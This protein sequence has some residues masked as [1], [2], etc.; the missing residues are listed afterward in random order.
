MFDQIKY[1]LKQLILVIALSISIVQPSYAITAADIPPAS[2]IHHNYIIDLADILD[3]DTEA[4][5]NSAIAILQEHKNKAIYL[6]TV[7]AITEIQT[8]R[9]FKIIPATSPSRRFL[10]SILLNWNI[11]QLKQGNGI[12]FFVS[13]ADH[14]VEIRSGFNLKYILQDRHIQGVIDKIIIPKFKHSNFNKGI[15]LAIQALI[16]KIDNPYCNLL[17]NPEHS[18]WES[19]KK[20]LCWK[21]KVSRE[22]RSYYPCPAEAS[23]HGGSGNW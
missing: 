9:N 21:R 6:V 7:P 13:V 16:T 18:T 1:C 19:Q 12:L 22:D 3:T 20:A 10:E 5:I 14:S 8:Q 15:L 11:Q 17:P 2:D 4:K 23:Y